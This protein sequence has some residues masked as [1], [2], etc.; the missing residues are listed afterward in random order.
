MPQM[1][2]ETRHNRIKN[3]A[4]FAERRENPGRNPGVFSCPQYRAQI[5]A[6]YSGQK[7]MPGIAGKNLIPVY[8][9]IFTPDISGDQMPAIWR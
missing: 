9:H 2:G 1:A 4:R 8:R 5:H 3:P 6:R 7:F